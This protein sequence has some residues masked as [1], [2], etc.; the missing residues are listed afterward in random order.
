MSNHLLTIVFTD[1]VDS[2]L[3]TSL[4]PAEDG[5]ARDR[6]YIETIKTPHCHRMM[7]GLEAFGGRKVKDTGDGFFLVFED[8]VRAVRW[9][10]GVQQ[11]HHDEPIATPLGPLEVK[12]ALH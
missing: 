10:M 1:L 3:I 6:A 9:S 2:A 5:G 4:M 11:S 7:V 8:P 12:I